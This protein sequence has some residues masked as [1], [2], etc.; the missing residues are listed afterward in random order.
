MSQNEE[1]GADLGFESD[2]GSDAGAGG[3]EASGGDGSHGDAEVSGD[4]EPSDALAV[5]AEETRVRILRTLAETEGAMA[6]SELRRAVGVADA[7]RFN[8][9]L[10]RVCEH[11]VRETESGY[12]LDRAGARLVTAADV[13]VAGQEP[14]ATDAVEPDPGEPCPVC[15]ESECGKLFHVHLSPVGPADR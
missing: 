9:H 7:G 3:K 15:G 5:L 6:F 1:C 2:A 14:E 4:G 12:E 11:F 10:S 13:D 8:Y